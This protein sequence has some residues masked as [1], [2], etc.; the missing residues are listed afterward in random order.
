MTSVHNQKGL[1]LFLSMHLLGKTQKLSQRKTLR[2]FVSKQNNEDFKVND[3]LQ[4][5]TVKEVKRNKIKL[6]FLF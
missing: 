5:Y 6:K 2:T 1:H 4:G 3:T